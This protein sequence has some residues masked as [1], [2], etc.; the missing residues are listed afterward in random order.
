LDTSVDLHDAS[1]LDEA[2]AVLIKLL[3][4]LLLLE[5]GVT[6]IL[7]TPLGAFALGA[8]AKDEEAFRDATVTTAR[9]LTRIFDLSVNSMKAFVKYQGTRTNQETASNSIALFFSLLSSLF[10]NCDQ[11]IH[12]L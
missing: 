1:V 10:T 7:S 2:N 8:N 6:K 9:I 3:L 5:R 11:H 4:L 12:T